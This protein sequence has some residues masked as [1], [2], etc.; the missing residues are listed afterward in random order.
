[1][2]ILLTH[3]VSIKIYM[4][5][6]PKSTSLDLIYYYYCYYSYFQEA[7]SRGARWLGLVISLCCTG[8]H[9][10]FEQMTHELLQMCQNLAK[11]E[12]AQEQITITLIPK[13]KWPEARVQLEEF[14][15]PGSE[16]KSW[17][18]IYKVGQWCWKP[19]YDWK[20]WIVIMPV[21]IFE[22]DYPEYSAA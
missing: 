13:N 19:C 11:I 10:L 8:A 7:V 5:K 9:Y 4:L 18:Q 20:P 6:T 16:G 1:M 22:W 15:R 2:G 17:W 21:N 14:W 12:S 3:T